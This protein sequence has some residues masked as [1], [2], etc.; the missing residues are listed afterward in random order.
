MVDLLGEIKEDKDAFK[1]CERGISVASDDVEGFYQGLSFLAK[2]E[3]LRVELGDIGKKYVTARYSKE[4]LVHD[5]TNF[6]RH[7]NKIS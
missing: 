3:N 2:S 7:L 6:Y 1:V 4:R 5:I